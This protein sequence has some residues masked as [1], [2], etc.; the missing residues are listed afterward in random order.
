MREALFPLA[1]VALVT[2]CNSPDDSGLFALSPVVSG[3]TSGNSALGMDAGSGGA[4]AVGGTGSSEATG[5]ALGLAGTSPG[6]ASGGELRDAGRLDATLVDA[7]LSD[8]GDA[9][10]DAGPPPCAPEQE[11]CDGRDNDCDGV[12]DAPGAC[13]AQ[14]E[15]FVL[16]DRSY[17]FCGGVVPMEEARARCQLEGMRL[18]WLETPAESAALVE[19][20]EALGV[21][22]T[23]GNPELLSWIGASDAAQE[24]DWRWV[25]TPAV[26]DG[27]EFWQGGPPDGE[28]QP[29]P[30]AYVSWAANEPNDGG[31]EDCAAISV[32]GGP[33][34]QR[35][36][37]DDRNCLTDSYPFLC[38]VP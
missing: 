17:M 35:E 9:A 13:G 36:Q 27:P 23:A 7:A 24:G 4:S 10:L 2:A 5:G 34:R 38:E 21:V 29:A 15:G 19:R 30:G 1:L 33:N 14:C 18:V 11:V 12:V 37:W 8:A 28:G 3:G 20:V 26:A 25:G 22:S 6:G 31:G 16:A 32:L